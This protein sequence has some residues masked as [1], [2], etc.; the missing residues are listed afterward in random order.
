MTATG[1]ALEQLV[2]TSSSNRLRLWL[3]D[4]AF[5]DLLRS[6]LAHQNLKLRE[7]GLLSWTRHM[8]MVVMQPHFDYQRFPLDSHDLILRFG[9]LAYSDDF[10]RLHFS[11]DAVSFDTSADPSSGDVTWELNKKWLLD[12]GAYST[13]V[14]SHT[15]SVTIDEELAPR[16]GGGRF[17]A[18]RTSSGVVVTSTFDYASASLQAKRISHGLLIR[19]GF[20][21]LALMV[22]AG[23]IFWASYELRISSTMRILYAVSALYIVIFRNVP[24]IGS[25]TDFDV[26]ILVMYMTITAAV[27]VHQ[28]I[29][30]ICEK[31]DRRPLRYLISRYIQRLYVLSIS[32]HI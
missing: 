17:V 10:L 23:L 15:S 26:Y 14:E 6:S 2:F 3:P 21:I 27:G 16:H 32:L 8:N 31:A 1:I 28:F 12:D 22:L 11:D 20:P 29:Y 24:M 19:L 30:R 5:V 7:D 13:H 9:S 25:S 18:A 4:V